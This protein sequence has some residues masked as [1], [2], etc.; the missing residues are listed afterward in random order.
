MKSLLLLLLV[1]S[2]AINIACIEDV[3][4]LK[5]QTIDLP[6]EFKQIQKGDTLIVIQIDNTMKVWFYHPYNDLED[7]FI[8]KHL[9]IVK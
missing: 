9:Y 6:E 8:K 7:S 3:H 5:V 1:A 4:P 2:I